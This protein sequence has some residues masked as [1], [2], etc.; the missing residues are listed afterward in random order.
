MPD[1]LILTSSLLTDRMLQHTGLLDRLGGKA[2]VEVWATSAARGDAWKRIPAPVRPFPA[3]AAFPEFPYTPLR[4]L[5][6]FTWDF[7][8]RPP[9]RLSMMRH[10]RDGQM[11][12][13]IRALKPAARLLA[14]IGAAAPLER[15]VERR[16]RAFCRSPEARERLQADRPALLVATNPFWFTEPA[17]VAVARGLSIPVVTLIPSWDNLSTKPRMVFSYDGYL[18]WSKEQRLQLDRFYPEAAG[19]PAWI[20]GAPQFDAFF[21]RRFH[22]T[23]A[24]FCAAHRL[25]PARPVVLYALGSPN[26]LKEHHGA[27]AMAERVRRGELGEVQMLVRP[28][29]LHDRSELDH[30][31]APFAP[32][33]VVQKTGD[34]G[35][36]LL[37]RTQ[38]DAQIADW[39]N[40]FRHADVVVNL[41]STVTVD[42]AIFNR[43]V[44][45]LDYD[46]EPGRPRQALVREIN[47]LWTHFRPV[48]ESGGV[49]LA[50]DEEEAARAI[51]EYLRNPALHTEGRHWIVRH[52]C[53][54]A[55]GRCGERM[56]DAILDALGR[57]APSPRASHEPVV[58][59][60]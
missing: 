14:R 29:P 55:D 49:W 6:E 34:A 18:L 17:V 50:P 51:R 26:F 10:V 53:G 20:V 39:V 57:A 48:A 36:T 13:W 42:A 59:G 47:H 46:P 21:Q 12:W 33:V 8:L 45:N 60:A 19:R 7:A 9:S 22:A 37:E 54:H 23:R 27:L 11:R 30:L 43:P 24:E 41:C 52:V 44:V 1:V 31:F 25:D 32:R 5:N 4:R 2:K 35:R 28:H 38:D 16:L 40:T 15:F 58:A 56:A 3:V